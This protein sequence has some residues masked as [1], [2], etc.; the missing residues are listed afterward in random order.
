VLL[1][2]GIFD[3]LQEGKSDKLM[4]ALKYLTPEKVFVIRNNLLEEVD[5]QTLV[6]GDICNVKAGEKVPADLRISC[7]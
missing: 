6:P 2:T 1:V 5:S 3:S 7:S 4:A